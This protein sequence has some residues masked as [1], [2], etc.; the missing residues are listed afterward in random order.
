MKK[1]NFQINLHKKINLNFIISNKSNSIIIYLNF[2]MTNHFKFNFLYFN[3]LS[4]KSSFIFRLKDKYLKVFLCI[5]CLLF[6]QTLLYSYEILLYLF[7]FFFLTFNIIF[8][9]LLIIIL[10]YYVLLIFT[11]SLNFLPLSSYSIIKL[12]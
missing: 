6:S 8:F 3:Y 12:L 1:K 10:Y 11:F 9:T 5:I 4:Y 7:I 2:M